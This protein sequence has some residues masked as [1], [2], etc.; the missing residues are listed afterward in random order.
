MMHYVYETE[1]ISNSTDA[2]N[3]LVL[4]S[5]KIIWSGANMHTYGVVFNVAL[6]IGHMS[7]IYSEPITLT[8]LCR[9]YDAA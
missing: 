2:K 4:T 9:L 8:Q 7:F 6:F 3:Q 1:T 5:A